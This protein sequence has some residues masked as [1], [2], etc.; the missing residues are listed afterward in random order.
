MLTL[1]Y[2]CPA[3][4][5]GD[6]NLGA[7]I[8]L[9][10]NPDLLKQE[11]GKL[12]LAGWSLKVGSD[13]RGGIAGTRCSVLPEDNN[14]PHEHSGHAHS[15]DDH[16]HDSNHHRTF[17][18]IR[19]MILE[20]ALS[21]RVKAD[22]L[23]CFQVLAEAEGKVHG[24]D[25]ERVHF[26]EVGAVDSIIDVV[27][28]A[29][30]WELLEVDSLAYSAL[31][32]GGG[33]VTCAH[34]LMPVPAPATARLLENMQTTW[35][36][37]DKEATTPT[38]AALLRGKSAVF[39]NNIRGRLCKNGI[40]IGQ[41]E[42]PKLAN[43]LY[44]SLIETVEQG[45]EAYLQKEKVFEI[46]VNLD[47]MTAE[48]KA[49]LR[50]QILSKGALD[51]WETAA[52]FKKGRTGSIISALVETTC[53]E[54]VRDVF[55]KHSSTLGV[56]CR[57]WDRYKLER[58]TVAMETPWGVVHVKQARCGNRFLRQKPD[59][60]DCARIAMSEEISL[61]EVERRLHPYLEQLKQAI[62]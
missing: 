58:A 54:A 45:S 9:G 32:L 25:P 59:F 37:T 46:S 13:Q 3:G 1:L 24:I 10:V 42:D 51:V 49:F 30:C 22:A 31:E 43:V 17:S 50:E 39:A 47:D 23:A 20:S 28:A 61:N 57:E 21:E 41:R 6:M 16:G 35:G 18:D 29:I 33:T 60:D 53:M 8:D 14:H 40:G 15:H 55:F 27:G 62:K 52:Q 11:L 12:P 48:A 5:C 7:M 34:G 56:R 2:N 44:V 36:A 26:H 38:G 19:K 4:I